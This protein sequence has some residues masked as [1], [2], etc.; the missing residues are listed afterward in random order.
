MAQL[1]FTNKD[2]DIVVFYFFLL[3]MCEPY[4]ITTE[5]P[6]QK[7]MLPSLEHVTKILW[8]WWATKIRNLSNPFFSEHEYRELSTFHGWRVS[9][10]RNLI[11]DIKLAR[12]FG[13]VWKTTISMYVDWSLCC[14][15]PM[16]L[17][18]IF[19]FN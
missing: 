6:F 3:R 2:V 9:D 8:C 1:P 10:H 5:H 19:F 14:K 4:C 11:N 15:I 13:K 17:I 18:S 7:K 12:S 16:T